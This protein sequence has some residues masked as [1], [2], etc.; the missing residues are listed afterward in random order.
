MPSNDNKGQIIGATISGICMVLAAIIGGIFLLQANT[1]KDQSTTTA[2]AITQKAA[3]QPE[4]KTLVA[5]VTAT[6]LAV[7]QTS[8]AQ[9][10]TQQPRSTEMPLSRLPSAVLV[11]PICGKEQFRIDFLGNGLA[12]A[13]LNL[14]QGYVYAFI[15]SD[16]AIVEFSGGN[17]LSIGTQ[18]DLVAKD[19][20]KINVKGVAT[21]IDNGAR[22]VNTYA[23]I[24]G[25]GE[26]L[27]AEQTA[28]AD[29]DSR[30]AKGFAA[31]L[32]RVDPQGSLLLASTLN[33]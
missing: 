11:E 17:P 25:G 24:Y 26:G 14:P 30:V 2:S 20:T 23:C 5:V 10:Q 4:V 3:N 15:T 27:T 18:F 32:F 21:R 1:S 22:V 12:N 7:P 9:I 13:E 19:F 6:P 33:K 29:Y 28:R 31:Q 16:P 8:V